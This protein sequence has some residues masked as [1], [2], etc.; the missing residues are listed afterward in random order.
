MV[1]VMAK[2]SKSLA[3]N[4]RLKKNRESNHP[5]IYKMRREITLHTAGNQTKKQQGTLLHILSTLIL[6]QMFFEVVRKT[7]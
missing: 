4:G 7:C 5:T 2:D 1:R 3:R 6:L